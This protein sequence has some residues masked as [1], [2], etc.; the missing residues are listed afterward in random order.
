K[1]YG[2]LA[3][4]K[5]FVAAVEQG[6]ES[7]MIVEEHRCGVRIEPDDPAALAEAILQM[8]HEP[9]EDMGRRGREAFERAFD[10]P[11]ATAGYIRLL[12]ELVGDGSGNAGRSPDVH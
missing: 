4:G 8:E 1:V 12:E 9:L 6:S 2:I 7:A 3:A 11:I 10:R 5:P